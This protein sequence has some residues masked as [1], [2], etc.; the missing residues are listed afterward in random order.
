[1][2]FCTF[3]CVQCVFFYHHIFFYYFYY[4]FFLL[5]MTSVFF[6]F[7][8]AFLF[9]LFYHVFLSCLFLLFVMFFIIVFFCFCFV[10][11]NL[12]CINTFVFLFFI[13]I[14]S[15]LFYHHLF[16][17]HYS[18]AFF[19]GNTAY[20]LFLSWPLIFLTLSWLSLSCTAII[21]VLVRRGFQE[22]EGWRRG[23]VCLGGAEASVCVWIMC[24]KWPLCLGKLDEAGVKWSQL[25]RVWDLSSWSLPPSPSLPPAQLLDESCCSACCVAAHCGRL[26]YVSAREKIVLWRQKGTEEHE[27][28][29]EIWA[30][31]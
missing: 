1:M 26:I 28:L 29:R 5:I 31:V 17:F 16:L 9:F 6:F 15:L 22:E 2:R 21:L 10:H 4:D 23:E 20:V 27:R 12:F 19:Y 24:C 30:S 13:C 18:L 11:R 3:F 25:L 8:I 7:I 14:L